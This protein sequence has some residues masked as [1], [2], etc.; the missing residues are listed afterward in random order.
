MKRPRQNL[1]STAIHEAGHAVI[2]RVL[3]IAC[4]RATIVPDLDDKIA[5]HAITYD[6]HATMHQWGQRGHW[7]EVHYAVHGYILALMAGA[8]AEIVINGACAG[9]DGEDRHCIA[10]AADSSDSNFSPEKWTRFEPRMRR[11]TRRLVR[12]HREKIERVAADLL[13]PGHS[14][15]TR[16][17]P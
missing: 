11:Q 8:E 10:V 5:G 4:G 7:R 6:Q 16:S 2:A 13:E 15:P 9:G 17:M 3:G 1:R 14:K 12:K